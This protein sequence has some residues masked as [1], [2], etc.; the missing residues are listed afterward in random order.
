MAQVRAAAD[1]SYSFFGRR[2][3][4]RED[5]GLVPIGEA[6]ADLP[7]PVKALRKTPGPSL[8]KF[9][10]TLGVYSS[11]GGTRRDAAP[12]ITTTGA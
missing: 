12:T 2:A 8:T 5:D 10:K 7:G 3:M 6:L 9:M 1:D 4:K 11:G